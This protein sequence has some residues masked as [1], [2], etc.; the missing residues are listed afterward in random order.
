MKILLTHRYFWPDTAPYAVMLR[1]IGDALA[2]ARCEVHIFSSIASYRATDIQSPQQQQLGPL[3]VRRT[4]VFSG[5]KSSPVKRLA[6][7]VIYCVALF[8]EVLRLRPAVV[9]AST[10]PPVV[11]AWSASLASRITGAQFIY[12]MQD[13]HPEVAQICGDRLGR[14]HPM[15]LLRWLDNQTLRRSSAIIVLSQD[16]AE[17]LQA[18]GLKDLPIHIIN[19]FSLDLVG[20]VRSAP[21]AELRKPAGRRRIIFAGNLG[22]FQNLSLLT[23]GVALVLARHPDLEL[24]FLGDGT[25]TSK[26]KHQ[27]GSHPQITFGKF[28][29]FEQARELIRESDIG[30]VSL[31]PGLFRAAF[32][33]KV[34]TYLGLGV[35]ILALVEPNSQLARSLT[36]SRLGTVPAE[37]TPEAI[38]ISLERLLANKIGSRAILDWYAAH[39]GVEHVIGSWKQIIKEL[40]FRQRRKAGMGT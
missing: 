29:P 14:G 11:A 28:L 32:P 17:T 35:P 20:S 37:N 21:P 7:A 9:T 27:W 34:L 12:H 19:N 31:S 24:L 6:N 26:L 25:M 1:T 30:L 10:F 40:S 22:R 23:E 15:H 2:D 39:A 18:R 5:E 8:F 13:I 38:A 3:N 33:S 4:W 16:M 36:Q